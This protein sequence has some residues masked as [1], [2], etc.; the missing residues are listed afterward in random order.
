MSLPVANCLR[1]LV[2]APLS[3][4]ISDRIIAYHRKKRG[5]WYPEDRL[6]V[7]LLAAL[8]LVPLTVLI[9]ALLVEYVP[10]TLGLMLSLICLFVSGLGVIF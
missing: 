7:T 10:G 2:G 1:L 9:F 6:R 3:G 5:A 4:H 8:T